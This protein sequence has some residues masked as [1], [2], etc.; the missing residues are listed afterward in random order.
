MNNATNYF[1][2]M[3]KDKK[4]FTSDYKLAQHMGLAPA[5]IANY[6]S[7][8]RELDD[9]TCLLVADLLGLPDHVVL[10]AVWASREKNPRIR[11]VYSDLIDNLSV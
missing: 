11:K 2:N 3:L 6:R 4:K 5:R 9:S 1:L 10:L 7:G 8:R